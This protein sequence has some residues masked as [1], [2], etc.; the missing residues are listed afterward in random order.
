MLCTS[1]TDC[2]ESRASPD[3]Q[4]PFCVIPSCASANEYVIPI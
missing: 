3:I 2:K 4:S 1:H